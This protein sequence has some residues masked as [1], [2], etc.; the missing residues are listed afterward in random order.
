MMNMTD[1]SAV[2]ERIVP[3]PTRA[4]QI[5]LYIAPFLALALFKIWASLGREPASLLIAAAAM[6]VYCS[7]V[8][9]LAK[10]WD[11]PTYF[12]WAVGAYFFVITVFLALWPGAAGAIVSQ[13]AVTGIYCCLFAA[14]FV[15]PLLGLEP[16]TYHYA[17]K[18]APRAVW[19]TP[20]FVSI[21][22]IMTFAWAGLLAV[23]ILI[24]LYP[25]VIT[26]ALIPISLIVGV[27]I[28]FNFRF[29]DYYLRRVGLPTIAEMRKF[30]SPPPSSISPGASSASNPPP[31][32]GED[33]RSVTPE[34]SVV[35]ITA[36][37]GPVESNG[38]R[39]PSDGPGRAVRTI[40]QPQTKKETTMK[41]M[42]INSSAR[43]DGV[44]KTAIMLDALVQ[45]MRDAGA[46]VEVIPLRKK[47]VKNCIGCFTCWTKTPGVCIHQDDMANELFP[48]WLEA[49]IAVYATPLYHFT[50]NAA[51]KA[52]IERTLPILEPF[53]VQVDGK[54]MHPLRQ[55]FPKSVVLSVA[56][57]PEASVFGQL[58]SYVNFVFRKGLI[59]EIYRP[60][61][62]G[63]PGVPE[64]KK[65][66]LDATAQAGR[67]IVQS[68]KI[69][70]ATMGRITQPIADFDASAKMANAFWKTCIQE[71]VTPREFE[72]KNMIPRPDS[73]DT[74]MM[75]M[76]M[77]FNPEAAGATKA[78]LQLNFSGE[79]EG[80]CYFT[81]EN[82]KIQSSAGSAEKPD[83]VIESPFEIWMDIMTGK[84][85]GQQMFM[86]QKYKTSGDLS[87]LMRMKGLFGGKGR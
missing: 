1:E 70:E 5:F 52:F 73:I 57:F 27:G 64:K 28:P 46:E 78:V 23:C 30:G 47:T 83:L 54:T 4:Q 74:F 3:K 38:L 31:S 12:D 72:Q 37:G 51:M 25:S 22:R 50:V 58:S 41:V 55:E 35:Q 18:Y 85:D 21:N 39:L 63:M 34:Q 2:R 7:A 60:G 44:S 16:F 6:L 48:K 9:A 17:K 68:N 19:Q 13:Y 53:M 40:S 59:A 75:I 71:G 49:D 45:G 62:E 8:V 76:S 65:D 15:P 43:S 36:A 61:A 10:H 69:S 79:V 29:P 84:A 24:S 33:G 87:L 32:P 80:S 26:R 56:G 20:V 86:E 82:G 67:E 66:I 11:K 81:I 77:G 42:A 14:A